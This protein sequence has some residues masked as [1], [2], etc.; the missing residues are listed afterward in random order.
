[1]AGQFARSVM[2]PIVQMNN[3]D[4][5]TE[6]H[7]SSVASS[8]TVARYCNSIV[9]EMLAVDDLGFSTGSTKEKVSTGI[10]KH[11]VRRVGGK[12]TCVDD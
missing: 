11:P 2:L 4:Q 7:I 12:T 8:C 6:I 3:L 5:P 1:M 9:T 10:S